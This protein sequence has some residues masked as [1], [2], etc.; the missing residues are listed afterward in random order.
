MKEKVVLAMSGGV[1]SSVAA[2]L[3]KQKGYDVSGATFILYE[4]TPTSDSTDTE[5]EGITTEVRDA[6]Q[7]TEKIGINHYVFN[8]RREFKENV[9]DKFAESYMKGETP[10][11]CVTCNKKI[12]FSKMMDI[13]DQLSMDLISTGHYAKISYDSGSERHLLKR[14]LDDKKDQTYVL[15]NLTQ[16]Q[17]AMT[18]LPLGLLTKKEIREFAAEHGFANADKPDSQDIC[19]VKDGDYAGFLRRVCG[20]VS[21]PGSF[22]DVE[23]RRLGE[24]K[25]MIN[26]TLGQRKGLGISGGRPLFV[27]KKDIE[28]NDIILGDNTDLC[29]TRV[30]VSD[31]N[32]IALTRLE[33]SMRVTAKMRYKQKETSAII[34]PVSETDVIVEFQE[35][36]RAVT[37]GQSAVF[38][39]GDIVLGGGII[40]DA[41]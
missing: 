13:A 30:F 19:F 35:G 22:I 2:L 33:A 8:Y 18:L 17:L 6:R 28:K 10:N 26:Y 41:E 39:D 38:Y 16:Q 15:Y 37:P 20:V 27:V 11:P 36:Q 40:R 24:H 34:H 3:L 7:V 9:I 12:K 14:A 32:L 23:G 29:S 1:D 31:V 4:D 25:G 5:T 21:K